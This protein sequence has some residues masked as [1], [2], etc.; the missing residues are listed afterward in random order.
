[1]NLFIFFTSILISIQL[2]LGFDIPEP[3]RESMSALHKMCIEKTG[4]SLEHIHKCSDNQIGDDADA[5]C[6]IACLNENVNLDL[7]RKIAEIQTVDHEMSDDIHRVVDHVKKE[8]D[9]D[10]F[11][12][13][14]G[15]EGP[16]QKANCHLKA[17]KDVQHFC[18]LVKS[19][20]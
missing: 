14:G 9:D 12:K 7:N 2:T 8:C 17:H 20:N 13:I 19:F 4:A 3:I 6:Y 11:D 18:D 10:Y 15:C 16:W 1:M 5:K